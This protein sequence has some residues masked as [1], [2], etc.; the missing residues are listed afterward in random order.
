MKYFRRLRK[1]LAWW[2]GIARY[3][4]MPRE[5]DAVPGNVLYCPTV[6]LVVGTE[7]ERPFYKFKDSS[8]PCSCWVCREKKYKRNRSDVRSE[9]I[10][11]LDE[12]YEG[13]CSRFP[14]IR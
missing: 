8:C 13:C 14:R 2:N 5:E 3:Y 4:P 11:W 9:V 7:F 10:K 6:K 12:D 1:Q